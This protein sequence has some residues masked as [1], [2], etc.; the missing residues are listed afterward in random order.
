M[1]FPS[2]FVIKNLRR[3]MLFTKGKGVFPK[4]NF[5]LNLFL[6]DEHDTFGFF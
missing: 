6:F 3:F 4:N 5:S 1:R 2:K